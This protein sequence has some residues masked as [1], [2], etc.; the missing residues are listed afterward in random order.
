[1]RNLGDLFSLEFPRQR[2]PIREER[3]ERES[4][5]YW[6]FK[7]LNGLTVGK[8]LYCISDI[9]YIFCKR[10]LALNCV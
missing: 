10:I 2:E 7:I 6:I 4:T 9:Y 8:I 5:Q 1:M 3:E